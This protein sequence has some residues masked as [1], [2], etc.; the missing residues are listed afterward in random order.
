MNLDQIDRDGRIR[1]CV[2]NEG[3]LREVE[4]IISEEYSRNR[5]VHDTRRLGYKSSD[6]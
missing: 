3:K 1:T 4:N 2:K 5:D 6:L